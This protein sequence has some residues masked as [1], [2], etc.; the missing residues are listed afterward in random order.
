MEETEETKQTS[1]ESRFKIERPKKRGT[2]LLVIAILIISLIGGSAAGYG[3]GVAER[4]SAERTQIHDQ[5]A[6]QYMLVEEDIT[7]GRYDAARQRLEFI[8]SHNGDFPGAGDKLAEVLVQLAITPSPVPTNTP[9]LT[10]TP[11]LRDQQ[12]IFAQA[13]QQFAVQDWTGLMQSLDSLRKKDPTYMAAK[14][15]SM[16][17]TALRERGINQILG[18]NGYQVTNLEGGIYDLG[19]ADNFS[20]LD[21]Y[22]EGLRNFASAY[23]NAAANW[24]V[25]WATAVDLFRQVAASVPNLRDASNVT[26]SQRLYQAL[27]KWGDELVL[28]SDRKLRCQGYGVWQ[29]AKNMSGLDPEY[30]EKYKVIKEE[31]DPKP[32]K[33]PELEV[34]PSEEPPPIIPT[35]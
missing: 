3:E 14:I 13:E 18:I 4:L 21:G 15:D 5:L 11:D 30:S 9:T 20:P 19:M 32:T 23:I 8:I 6:D 29:E 1:S 12:T 17:Y 35:P 33:T 31:C 25:D 28:S 24:D 10:P 7:A 2:I 34:P 16:Y 27:L 22:A 26:A